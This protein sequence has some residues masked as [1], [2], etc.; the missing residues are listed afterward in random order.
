MTWMDWLLL[1]LVVLCGLLAIRSTRKAK[2]QGKCVGCSGCAGG[3]D[4][5]M[6]KNKT[7][8]SAGGFVLTLKRALFTVRAG[9]RRGISS[10]KSENQDVKSG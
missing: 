9:E 5:C 6:E 8:G 1:A 3:C 7:S 10:E 4:S 2:K